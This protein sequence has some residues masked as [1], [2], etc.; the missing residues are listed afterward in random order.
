MDNGFKKS[1]SHTRSVI[2]DA[3][4][5]LHDRHNLVVVTKPSL[6]WIMAALLVPILAFIAV[7]V[8]MAVREG[9]RLRAEHEARSQPDQK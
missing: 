7:A 1:W 9:K 5:D 4:R 3:R 2:R 8:P 6:A